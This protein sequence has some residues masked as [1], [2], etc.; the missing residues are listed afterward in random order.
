MCAYSLLDP[1]TRT[2]TDTSR[3]ANNISIDLLARVL[4]DVQ[5]PSPPN[6]NPKP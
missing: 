1:K 6:L 3:M 2:K 4:V 5:V